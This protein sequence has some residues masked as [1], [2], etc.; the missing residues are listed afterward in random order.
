LVFALS[1]GGLF[2]GWYTPTEAGA[3]GAAGVLLITLLTGKLRW[4]GIKQALTDT[5]RTTAMIMLLVAGAIIF[6]HFIAVT[7][8]PNVL[9]SS[10]GNLDLPRHAIL[11]LIVLIYLVL[12]CFIDALALILLTIP[13]FYPVAVNTLQYDPVWFGVIIVLVV[14]LGVITPPVGVNVYIIKGI[15]KDTPL[16]KIFA[17]IWPFV[18]ALVVCIAILMLFPQ[19]ITYLPNHLSF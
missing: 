17:G 18:I 9:A 11:G 12:G 15:A 3:V 1:I 16:E 14:A 2:A 7:Q 5:T 6:G 10:V 4:P 13:I 8:I 19:I